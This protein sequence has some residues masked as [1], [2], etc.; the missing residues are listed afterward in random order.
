M[1]VFY[2]LWTGRGARP[3]VFVP[4]CGLCLPT[5]SGEHTLRALRTLREMKKSSSNTNKTLQSAKD[6]TRCALLHT[7]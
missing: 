1:T 6:P 5:V 4:L 2:V 3:G 7:L